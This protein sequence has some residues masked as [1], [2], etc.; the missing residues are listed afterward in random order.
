MT[1]ALYMD[2]HVKR[3]VTAG[4]RRRGVDVLTAFE[5]GADTLPESDLLDRATALTRVLVTQDDD[6]LREGAFRQQHGVPFTGLIYAHQQSVTI[7]Q[8]VTDLELIAT[9]YDPPDVANQVIYLPL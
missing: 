7:G 3:Q 4:L 9:V 8:F 6:L 1:L 2:H 5:D